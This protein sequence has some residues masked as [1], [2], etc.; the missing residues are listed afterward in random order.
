M[1]S[2][3]ILNM[4]LM[5][6]ADPSYII[7]DR[8]QT[9]MS[10]CI[11]TVESGE[12]NRLLIGPVSCGD[13]LVGDI[14]CVY[15][16]RYIEPCMEDRAGRVTLFAII[17]IIMALLIT[18]V[19]IWVLKLRYDWKSKR[20]RQQNPGLVTDIDGPCV[21]ENLVLLQCPICIEDMVVGVCK[22]NCEHMYHR[23]CIIPWLQR[24]NTCPVCRK[25]L[26]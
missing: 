18:V 13:W 9:N 4:V 14:V 15:N 20:V 16:R 12:S 6:T 24:N 21:D 23:T 5:C 3:V 8:I 17:A 26:W 2:L 25:H 19:M 22:I 11:F 1:L 7:I 10:K